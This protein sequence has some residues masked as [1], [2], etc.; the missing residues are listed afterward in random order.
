MGSSLIELKENE[1]YRRAVAEYKRRQERQADAL[2]FLQMRTHEDGDDGRRLVK[3]SVKVRWDDAG[4]V[5]C[6]LSTAGEHG[7]EVAFGQGDEML[8]ALVNASN[9]WANGQLKWKEDS[10]AKQANGT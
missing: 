1:K 10:Y 2:A 6:V 9:R 8:E 3:V 4:D 5:L 7:N